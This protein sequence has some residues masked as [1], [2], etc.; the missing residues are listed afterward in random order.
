[1]SG[2]GFNE[3]KGKPFTAADVRFT[4]K[5]DAV[6]AFVMGWPADGK[7]T[8]NAMRAGSEHLK[9][10]ISRVELVGRNSAL[11]FRQTAQGLQVTLP[12]HKPTLPYA[13][14]LKIV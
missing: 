13:Y 3:G 12:A 1:M 8:I 11:A 10:R 9:K 14:A 7:V 5:N 4:V 2:A 6:Y